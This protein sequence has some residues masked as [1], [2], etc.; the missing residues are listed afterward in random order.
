MN[1]NHWTPRYRSKWP[2]LLVIPKWPHQF[3]LAVV[4]GAT[5]AKQPQRVPTPHPNLL[6]GGWCLCA[7]FF[8]GQLLSSFPSRQLRR[9]LREQL[10]QWMTTGGDMDTPW[11]KMGT[12]LVGKPWKTV[13]STWETTKNV[14]QLETYLVGRLVELCFFSTSEDRGFKQSHMTSQ[15]IL[16]HDL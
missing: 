10:R 11:R 15:M 2:M 16:S 14:Q 13:V 5:R 8:P 1:I 3:R 4:A 12:N 6:R 7:D 9:H